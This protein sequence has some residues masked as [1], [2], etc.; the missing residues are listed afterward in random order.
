VV[1]G[2]SLSEIGGFFAVAV[3][4]FAVVGF[5]FVAAGFFFAVVVFFLAVVFFAAI[6]LSFLRRVSDEFNRMSPQRGDNLS[7]FL[8][9]LY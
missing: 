6:N 8:R 4:F 3:F 9:T 5:F 1:R 7:F 2:R